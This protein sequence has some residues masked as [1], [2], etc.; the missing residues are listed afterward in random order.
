MQLVWSFHGRVLCMNSL[1]GTYHNFLLYN[2]FN[3][4]LF[5]YCCSFFRQQLDEAIRLYEQC[6]E[7]CPVHTNEASLLPAVTDY[8][9]IRSLRKAVE[10]LQRTT[11]PP[12]DSSCSVR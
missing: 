11:A 10:T 1:L 3:I 8:V 7:V 5:V 4:L 12:V 6:I 9:Q 2:H